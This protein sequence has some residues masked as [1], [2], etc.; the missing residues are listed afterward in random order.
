[1]PLF[2]ALGR[3]ILSKPKPVRARRPRNIKPVKRVPSKALETARQN[4]SP[5]T[6]VQ[7]TLLAK[8]N[9]NGV[10]YGP[11]DVTAPFDVAKVLRENDQRAQRTDHNF[12][13]SRACIVGPGG[14]KG[15]LKV[16]EVAPEFFDTQYIGAVPFGVVNRNTA[17]FTPY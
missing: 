17:T 5:T 3:P 13:S 15:A 7:V 8:H 4:L 16:T 9:I 11:G 14:Q 1:M 12:A 10:Q 6:M 2:D